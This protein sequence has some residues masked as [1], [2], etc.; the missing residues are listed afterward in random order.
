MDKAL[1]LAYKGKS[2]IS[3]TIRWQ[4]RSE[5]SHI[6]IWIDEGVVEAWHKGGVRL[7]TNPDEGHTDGTP[8]DVFEP[9]VR[10]DERRL[11]NALLNEVGKAYDFHGCA[12]FLSRRD[13]P[14]DDRW[15]CSELA[16]WALKQSNLTLQRIPASHMAP[17]HVAMSRFLRP[18]AQIVTGREYPQTLKQMR[19]AYC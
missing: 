16:A 10:I 7:V 11:R 6:G 18:V 8:I 3:K 9:I 15:F 19:V 1:V 2:W 14:L 4:T 13:A 5:Y 17:A 12:R